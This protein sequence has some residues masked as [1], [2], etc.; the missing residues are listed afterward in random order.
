M[1]KY[2]FFDL[3]GTIVE[4]SKGI[5]NSI[6]Y[7]LDK[8]EV[9]GSIIFGIIGATIVGIPFGIQHFKFMMLALAPFG[10]KIRNKEELV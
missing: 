2:L 5:V 3:D 4:P 10:A 7:A 1:Y 6:L 8:L 9:K